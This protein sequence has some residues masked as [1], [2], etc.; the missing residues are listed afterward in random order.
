M[1]KTYQENL[2]IDFSGWFI[3]LADFAEKTDDNSSLPKLE[4]LLHTGNIIRGAI[5]GYDRSKQEKLLMVLGIS[6]SNSKSEITLIPSS[7]VAALTF[8]DANKTLEVIKNRPVISVLELKR[9]AKKTEEDLQKITVKK[10]TLVLDTEN[11]AENHRSFVLET[12]KLL[13]SIF[14]SLIEDEL[15][16]TAIEEKID[17]IKISIAESNKISLHN[18]E[19]HIEKTSASEY[20]HKQKDRI[21][22]EIESIL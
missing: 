12:I 2:F 21:K 5:I 7:Q 10:I 20:A 22:K 8:I 18:K 4:L 3:K 11:Y 19:L 16:K 13:P 9:T 14:E 1:I 15:G 17:S 6:D